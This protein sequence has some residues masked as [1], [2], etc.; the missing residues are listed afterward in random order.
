MIGK[1]DPH[2]KAAAVNLLLF[3]FIRSAGRVS[4]DPCLPL[5]H[6]RLILFISAN[7]SA[8]CRLVVVQPDVKSLIHD[9]VALTFEL[10]EAGHH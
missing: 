5:P 9:D 2:L 1:L 10:A 6:L 4:Q 7:C 3:E 8:M